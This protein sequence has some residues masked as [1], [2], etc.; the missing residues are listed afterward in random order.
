MMK[1]IKTFWSICCFKEDSIFLLNC[2]KR[3][4]LR[5]SWLILG[6]Y[7]LK[8][9]CKFSSQTEKTFLTF[10]KIFLTID[11][12]LSSKC[13]AMREFESEFSWFCWLGWVC[14]LPSLTS[15]VFDFFDGFCWSCVSVLEDMFWLFWDWPFD[16]SS[17]FLFLLAP[18][19]S[20]WFW[21]SFFGV[22]C[23]WFDFYPKEKGRRK[24]QKK[25]KIDWKKKKIHLEPFPWIKR[26]DTFLLQI[27][28]LYVC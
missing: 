26:L 10:L 19:G 8:N 17:A 3:L 20:T 7:F 21:L 1:I 28:S 6:F 4:D 5:S 13:K 18:F 11:F 2:S 24:D 22:S 25:N 15:S 16:N 23:F 14:C 9:D 27:C 12:H